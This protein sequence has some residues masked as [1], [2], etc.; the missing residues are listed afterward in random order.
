[1]GFTLVELL[2]VIGI[3]AIL[4]AILLPTLSRARARSQQ[5]ACMANLRSIGQ[6]MLMYVNDNRD[7]YPDPETVGKFI[8][9]RQPGLREPKDPSSY[10]E[11]RGIQAVLH[12]IR[13]NDYSFSMSANDVQA[14]IEKMLA[15]RSRYLSAVSKV[16]ICPAFPDKFIEYGNTYAYT[17]NATQ[18]KWTSV[19]RARAKN[20]NVLVAW[21]NSNMLPYLPGAIPGTNT[22]GYILSPAIYPHPH[23]EG[24]KSAGKGGRNELYFD[25]RVEMTSPG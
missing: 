22:T 4:I 8:F 18:A 16:W 3:I 25:G 2:V 11:W 6:S 15:N 10:P 23:F 14:S 20:Q 12:G 5:T 21:D 24:K 9:R 13:P 1:M 17:I 19:Q 7:H